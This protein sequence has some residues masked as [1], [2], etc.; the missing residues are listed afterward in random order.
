MSGPLQETSQAPYPTQ[1]PITPAMVAECVHHLKKLTNDPMQLHMLDWL[2]QQ[3]G[4]TMMQALGSM[5]S[6]IPQQEL[7]GMI[8]QH[9]GHQPEEV[10]VQVRSQIERVY[11]FF[12]SCSQQGVVFPQNG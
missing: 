12:L 11:S 8:E 5:V 2:Q 9:I 1:E 7:P 6:Q 3:D 10:K 4:Q